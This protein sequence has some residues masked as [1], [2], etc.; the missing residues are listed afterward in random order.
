MEEKEVFLLEQGP[1]QKILQ[2]LISVVNCP[3]VNYSNI[4]SHTTIIIID[5]HNG[6]RT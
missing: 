4:L 5:N 1:W 6:A 3:T 2:S